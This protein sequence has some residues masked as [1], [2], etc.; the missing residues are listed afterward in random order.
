MAQ[1]TSGKV[2]IEGQDIGGMN[3][4][5]RTDI[6]RK[7]LGF[8]FQKFNLLPALT[9]QANIDVA[10]KIHGVAAADGDAHLAEILRLLMIEEKIIERW[11]SGAFTYHLPSDYDSR[12]KMTDYA[13]LA[14][15]VYGTSITPEVLWELAPWSWAVDWFFNAGDVVNNLSD[16]ESA[17]LVMRYGYMME[18][19]FHKYTYIASG[20]GFKKELNLASVPSLTLVTETKKRVGAN[21]FGFGVTW[22]GLSPFQTSVLAALGISRRG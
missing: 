17:G 11:F 6:R 4:G 9:A 22:D 1:P 15:K 7:K 5:Q 3:D 2:L 21:P 12:S 20:T 14:D 13:S 19:T 10:R 16:W 8:V 18:H